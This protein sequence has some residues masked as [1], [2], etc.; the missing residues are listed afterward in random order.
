MSIIEAYLFLFFDSMLGR[1]LIPVHAPY[2]LHTMMEF[3]TYSKSMMWIFATLGSILGLGLNYF[4][5]RL[6]RTIPQ[7]P[8]HFNKLQKWLDLYQTKGCFLLIF[9]FIP[10]FGELLSVFSG[11]VKLPFKKFIPL[12]MI[13]ILVQLM[14]VIFL[15]G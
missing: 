3:G 15:M 7:E 1:M 9:S 11:L 12:T 2:V 4:L 5:G 14:V 6:L 13:S 10:I 8:I